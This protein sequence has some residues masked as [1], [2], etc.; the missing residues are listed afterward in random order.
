MKK[1]LLSIL[2]MILLPLVASADIVVVDVITYNCYTE[3]KEAELYNCPRYFSGIIKIPESVV[4]EGVKYKVTSI[5]NS[6]FSG[7]SD[8]TSITI[9]NSVTCIDRGAFYN[10]SSLKSI[11]IPHSV[12]SIG[13]SA[14]RDCSSLNSINIPNS[15]KSI[16]PEASKVQHGIITSLTDYCTQGS[17]RM[18]IKGKWLIILRL[19]LKTEL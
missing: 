11:I 3:T 18:N 12:T 8:L 4:C 15:V 7:C 14:F 5:G 13:E 19:Q 9:P 1:V 17:L 6:A 10:C 2:L 16:G